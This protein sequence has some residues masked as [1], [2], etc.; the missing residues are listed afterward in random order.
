MTEE[1]EPEGEPQ[2]SDSVIIPERAMPGEEVTFEVTTKNGKGGLSAEIIA[3]N[4]EIGRMVLMEPVGI[5]RFRTIVTFSSNTEPGE[6]PFAFFAASKECY[7]ISEFLPV[8][9]IDVV[10]ALQVQL[11]C[12]H[13]AWD[14]RSPTQ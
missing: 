9:H 14:Y 7:V 12:Q 3:A 2:L 10:R 13:P 8:E 1:Q 11:L 4:P 5:A 6:Y